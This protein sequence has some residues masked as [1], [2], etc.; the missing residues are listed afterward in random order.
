MLIR[1]SAALFL[2]FFVVSQAKACYESAVV[3]PSP[4]MGNDGEI[5]KL[6]D[7]TIWEIQFEYEYLYEYYPTIIACP[8]KD[9]IIV[10]GKR[11]SATMISSS[12]S[13]DSSSGVVE[14]KIDGDFEGFEGDT[15]YKLRDGQIW[16][17]T[18]GRYKYK[19]KYSPDVIIVYRGRKGKIH[20]EG[21]D[22]SFSVERLK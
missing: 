15:I 20:V 21:L 8:E 22:R 3:S 1:L 10:S 16:Q 6:I 9:Q 18:D 11:L 19:Y 2:G 17:Q 4:F 5:F 12:N 7:G 14:S 13:T